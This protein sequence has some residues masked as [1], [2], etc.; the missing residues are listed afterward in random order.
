MIFTGQKIPLKTTFTETDCSTGVTS[1][2]DLTG[3]TIRYDYWLP[4][5]S[6][7]VHDGNV[8][9]T[10]LV[11]LSGTA[12]GDILAATNNVAGAWKVQA[13]AIISGDEWPAGT[14]TFTV[15]NRGT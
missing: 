14:I 3:A 5:N 6:T 1:P 7:T 11:P 9:G 8:T 15:Q 4:T 2:V 10:V 12:E 13:N